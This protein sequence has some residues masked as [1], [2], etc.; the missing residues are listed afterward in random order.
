MHTVGSTPR[1]KKKA[2]L[3][4]TTLVR[5]SSEESLN[6][7]ENRGFEG[8]VEGNTSHHVQVAGGTND[9]RAGNDGINIVVTRAVEVV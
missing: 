5:D 9:T 1:N 4:S 3:Y 7:Q 8:I 2:E 6:P